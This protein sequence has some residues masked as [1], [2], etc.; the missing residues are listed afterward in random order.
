MAITIKEVAA[1][2]GVSTATVSRVINN[3]GYLS[4]EAVDRVKQAM[5]DLNYVPNTAAR[6][7]QGK[8]SMTI[9]VV[10]PSLDNPLY[11]ELFE[12]IESKLSTAHYQTLLCT[13][14]NLPDKEEEYFSLLRANRVEGIITSSHGDFLKRKANENYPIVCFDR[15]IS[16]KIPS[17]QS[18][19]LSG[20]RKVAD[21]TVSRGAKRVL[22]LSGSTE[23]LYPIDDRIKGMM[24]VFNRADIEL[25][26]AALEFDS[27][28]SVKALLIQKLIASR[29]YDAVCCT[30][31]LT[32]LM[33]KR[34]AD[35]MDYHPLVTGYDGSDFIRTFFP[36]L[37]TVCQPIPQMA[38]LMCNL[39]I[40]KI[41]NR[42]YQFESEY[43]FP[44]KLVH[45]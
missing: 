26:T 31:D 10:L 12:A 39:L 4:R 18:D 35:A 22:I 44:V 36:D 14:S 30:D 7:L 40:E 2:A 29:D 25:E 5:R 38:E 21:W 33:L 19:N 45:E 6:S 27:S 16:T 8:D 43:N 32:A 34:V 3:K 11:S 1:R 37:T 9:G 17:V 20:G 28:T 15:N 23:D 13:S 41:H 24:S 42:S